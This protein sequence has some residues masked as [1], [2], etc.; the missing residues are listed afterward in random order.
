M[1]IIPDSRITNIRKNIIE[2]PDL[3]EQY[4]SEIEKMNIDN[5]SNDETW[6]YIESD[7]NK[8]KN[9]LQNLSMLNILK[10]ENH[11][12]DC[13]LGLGK[14]LFDIYLSSEKLDTK[15]Y[16]Y[17]IEKE[18]HYIDLFEYHLMKFWNN[19][20]T[21]YNEDIMNHNYSKYNIVYTYTPF[22]SI[23]KLKTFYTK[24]L[25]EIKPGSILIEHIE[26]GKGMNNCLEDIT[27]D[28]NNIKKINIGSIYLFYKEK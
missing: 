10:E 26:D 5:L 19:N 21:L 11:I 6:H 22:K 28:K 2:K 14:T 16:F 1:P 25:D 17:G 12:C 13:G 23:E 8:N 24:I 7:K 15:S 27:E 3:Y 9:L 4:C 18:Q 20:I